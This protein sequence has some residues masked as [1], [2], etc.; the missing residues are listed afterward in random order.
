MVVSEI[1]AVKYACDKSDKRKKLYLI[2]TNY[3]HVHFHK[4]KKT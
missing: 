4:Q 2:K 1:R 3:F